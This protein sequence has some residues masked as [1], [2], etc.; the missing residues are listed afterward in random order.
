MSKLNIFQALLT[1]QEIHTVYFKSLNKTIIDFIKINWDNPSSVK[2]INNDIPK[3]LE[4]D[5]KKY[6]TVED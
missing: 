2:I 1:I 5:I 4:N 3:E 6:L